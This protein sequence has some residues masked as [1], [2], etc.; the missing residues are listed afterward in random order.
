MP[1]AL[2]VLSKGCLTPKVCSQL[3]DVSVVIGQC[4]THAANSPSYKRSLA[5]GSP[6]K[7]EE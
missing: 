5:G 4:L 7:G 2:V 1:V 3:T 6:S